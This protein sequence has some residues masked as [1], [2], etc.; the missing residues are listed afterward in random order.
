MAGRKGAVTLSSTDITDTTTVGRNLMKA[1]R[2]RSGPVR[3]RRDFV[4]DGR[5]EAGQVR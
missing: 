2:R 4:G 5:R 3:D 1:A